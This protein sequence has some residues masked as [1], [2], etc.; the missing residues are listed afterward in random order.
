[1]GVSADGRDRWFCY[2]AH[3]QEEQVG[4]GDGVNSVLRCAAAGCWRGVGPWGGG[5]GARERRGGGGG[6]PSWDG[7]RGRAKGEQAVRK[8]GLAESA[9]FLSLL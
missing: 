7:E 1:M 2:V 4:L 5:R 9:N 3:I 8:G 6:V